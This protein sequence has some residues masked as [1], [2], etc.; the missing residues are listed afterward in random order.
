MILLVWSL[1]DAVLSRTNA[2][3]CW[4]YDTFLNILHIYS[5][6]CLCSYILNII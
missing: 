6:L 4:Y 1:C 2:G 3:F 5:Y